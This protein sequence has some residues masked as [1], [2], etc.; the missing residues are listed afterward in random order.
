MDY[1]GVEFPVKVKDVGVIEDTNEIYINVFSYE[2]KIV[3]RVYVSKKNYD[4]A[5]NLLM[6]RED[7]KSHYVYVKDFNRLMFN[8]N[9]HKEKKWFCMRCL[10][11]FSSEIVLENHKSDCLV[12]KS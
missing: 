3:C 9:K 11:H 2:D 1:D 12:V 10:Q 5:M 7:D 8:V 4:D 6:I